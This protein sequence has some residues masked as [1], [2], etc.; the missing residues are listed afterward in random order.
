MTYLILSGSERSSEICLSF[1]FKRLDSGLH[2][3]AGALCQN[4]LLRRMALQN[5]FYIHHVM[6]ELWRGK[7]RDPKKQAESSEDQKIHIHVLQ[8]HIYIEHQY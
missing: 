6:E 1:V 2:S 4:E 3:R 5:S 8:M 7:D